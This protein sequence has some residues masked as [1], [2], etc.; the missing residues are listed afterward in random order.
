MLAE[1]LDVAYVIVVMPP[2]E[3]PAT[4]TG[5]P[6][7]PIVATAVL[8]LVHMPPVVASL[9]VIVDALHITVV[10]RIADIGATLTVA[11]DL[12]PVDV[13]RYVIVPVPDET[14]VTIPDSEPTEAL[15]EVLLLQ[16]PPAV[17][18]LSV[19]VPPTHTDA[20]APMIGV[21][22]FTNNVVLLTQPVDAIVYVTV[23]EPGVIPLTTPEVPEKYAIDV[24]PL[25]H[26]PPAVTSLNDVVLPWHTLA[27]P[28]IDVIGLTDTISVA[29]H[30]AGDV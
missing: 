18:S 21:I 20:G 3:T 28:S 26:V 25:I 13:T 4:V 11:V 8:L 15:V 19:T 24:F 29:I 12:Q 22:G 7:A 10:P 1:Q 6:L 17:A 16:T 30:P 27:L 2:G 14:P 23:V 5:D 9:N